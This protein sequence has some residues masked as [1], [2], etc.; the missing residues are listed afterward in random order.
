[1]EG[2]SVNACRERFYDALENKQLK[3]FV[4]V[5]G[6][7]KEKGYERLI[8]AF[9]R[10]HADAPDT[11]LFILG[12]TGAMFSELSEKLYGRSCE[13][14]VFLVKNMGNPYPLIKE[15]DYYVSAAFY[16]GLGTNLADA[17]ILGLPCVATDVPGNHAFMQLANGYLAENSATG[18]EK[19]LRDCLEGKVAKKLAVDYEQYNREAVAQFESL[20]P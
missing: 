10:V 6:F 20:L 18:V 13:N 8:N 5:G 9:E 11:C 2:V 3:K 19:A 12:E 15:C 16:E 1:M 14:A 4:S 17:D 7:S